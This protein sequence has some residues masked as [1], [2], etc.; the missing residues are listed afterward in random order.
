MGSNIG[1]DKITLVQDISDIDNDKLLDISL[2]E[3]DRKQNKT[4]CLFS[5][6]V[7]GHTLR[8]LDK[9]KINKKLEN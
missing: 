7:T 6:T 1:K 2:E 4:N 3:G 5:Y 9:K 8:R